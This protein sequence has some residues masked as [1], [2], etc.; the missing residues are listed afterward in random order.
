MDTQ[1][2]QQFTPRLRATLWNIRIDA[3]TGEVV[4]TLSERGIPSIVLKGA[5][6]SDWYPDDS[7]RTYVDGD[8]WVAPEQVPM[9]ERVLDELGFVPKV[10]ERGLPEWWLEHASSWQ[11]DTD[12]GSIDLHRKLQG[13]GVSP[14]AAWEIL[15]P[16]SVP[17]TVGGEHARRLS[18]AARAVYVTLHATHHGVRHG[19]GLEHVQAALGSVDD[20]TWREAATLAQRLGAAEWFS[21]GL[22]LVPSGE[23]LAD[24]IGLPT[25]S[26]V[27]A[28]LQAS[29]APPVALGFEQL[30]AA[31]GWGQRARIVLRKLVPPPGFIRH[32]WP[33][34][35]RGP[36][37]LAVGYV[38]RPV[39]LARRGP[40]GWRAWRAAGRAAKRNR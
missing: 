19:G 16:Q 15:W 39:W 10:D 23:A 11:R 32:W 37:M 40:A 14:E 21:T 5:A 27:R 22:R 4:R 35:A 24:R 1:D 26:S 6:L 3:A 13:V 12:I 31:S 8:I 17:M 38:Y 18:P 28:S 2:D 9:A 29:T 25:V 30:A 7:P 33:P 20:D 34:A 36:L